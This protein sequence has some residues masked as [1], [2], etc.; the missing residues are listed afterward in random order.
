MV[1]TYQVIMMVGMV[2]AMTSPQ[3]TYQVIMMFG[4]V[5]AMMSPW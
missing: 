5:T 2:T 3:V 1:T 4:M